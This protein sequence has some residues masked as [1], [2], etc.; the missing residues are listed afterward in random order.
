MPVLRTLT[1][2]FFDQFFT[3]ESVTSDVELQQRVFWLLG[4]LIAPGIFILLIV[5][6]DFVSIALRAHAGRAPLSIIDDRLEWLALILATYAMAGTGFVTVLSWD[7][8][9]FDRRDAMVLGSLPLGRGTMMAAKLGALGA[10][11]V[12]GAGPI[13]LLYS[14][15]FAIETA[16]MLGWHVFVPHLI[17][18][19]VATGGAATFIFSAI[20]SARAAASLIGGPRLAS[21]LGPVLQFAFVVAILCLVILSPASSARVLFMS[22]DRADWLPPTWFVGLFEQLRHSPRAHVPHFVTI[23]QRCLVAMSLAIGAALL[24]SF[25]EFRRQLSAAGS[26][27][28]RT[29]FA[30]RTPRAIARAFSGASQSV[31]GIADFVILTMTRNRLPQAS[32]SIHAGFGAALVVAALSDRTP[33]IAAL[34][35][36]RT[37]VLWIP[38]VLA[39]WSSLGMRSSFFVPSEVKASWAFRANT[40]E[41]PGHWSAVRASMIGILGPVLAGTCLVFAPLLG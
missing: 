11:L 26:G 21:M 6:P 38:L 14:I 7:A 27:A 10:L 18:M 35:H 34:E 16:E 5:F 9:T 4:I 13:C 2:A 28:I 23:T 30:A 40:S 1:R 31:R 20:V 22:S 19:F 3:S 32:V 8:L 17:S 41:R 29:P 15:I 12:I 39:Y 33:D 25:V 24:G 37:V 36:P